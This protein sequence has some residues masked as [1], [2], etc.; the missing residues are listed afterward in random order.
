MRSRSPSRWKV[1]TR[2]K[3]K[4]VGKVRWKSSDCNSEVIK[5]NKMTKEEFNIIL[6]SV[7][8]C[9]VHKIYSEEWEFIA[10]SNPRFG[11]KIIRREDLYS[12]TKVI[13]YQFNIPLCSKS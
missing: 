6:K 3:W 10:I 7:K 4:Y 2:K 9:P 11:R 13:L 12:E 8:V 5:E 1:Y